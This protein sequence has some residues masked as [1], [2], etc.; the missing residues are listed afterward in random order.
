M[1]RIKSRGLPGQPSKTYKSKGPDIVF[2]SPKPSTETGGHLGSIRHIREGHEVVVPSRV[3]THY[4]GQTRHLSHLDKRMKII[5]FG[6][7]YQVQRKHTLYLLSYLFQHSTE[8]CWMQLHS[9][10]KTEGDLCKKATTKQGLE[11]V[12]RPCY[13]NWVE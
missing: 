4:T 10:L 13:D 8:G 6:T 3:E 1:W 9:L 11:I 12:R 5:F 2:E 7:D